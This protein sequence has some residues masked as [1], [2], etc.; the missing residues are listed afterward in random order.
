MP[1]PIRTILDLQLE[2]LRQYL[3]LSKRFVDAWA[4]TPAPRP[5]TAATVVPLV[6]RKSGMGCVGP[7]DL[8]G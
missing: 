7:A 1:E 2:L 8:R 5:A 3:I 4:M 6:K